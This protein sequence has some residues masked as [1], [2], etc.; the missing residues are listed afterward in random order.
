MKKGG[1]AFEKAKLLPKSH[2]T[3]LGRAKKLSHMHKRAFDVS[4]RLCETHNVYVQ[5]CQKIES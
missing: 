1:T 2:R 4:K 5:I 3:M